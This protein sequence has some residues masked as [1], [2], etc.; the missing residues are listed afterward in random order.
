MR[1]RGGGGRER[2][3]LKEMNKNSKS[4]EMRLIT[5]VGDKRMPLIR[6]S[7]TPVSIHKF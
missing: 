7:A 6:L 4:P 3:K 5:A 2:G 1:G